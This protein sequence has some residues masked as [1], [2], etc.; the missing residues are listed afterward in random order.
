MVARSKGPRFPGLVL[1]VIGA[2]LG[3]WSRYYLDLFTV[4]PS[5]R[6]AMAHGDQ[7]ASQLYTFLTF[8]QLFAL[9]AFLSGLCMAI[10]VRRRESG[11]ET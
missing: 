9:V 8:V 2:G 4:L 5:G 10:Y 1:L 3:L 7:G 6:D 11:G